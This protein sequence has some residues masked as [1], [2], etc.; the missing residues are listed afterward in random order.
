MKTNGGPG[1]PWLS[2]SAYNEMRIADG[3]PACH[4]LTQP[5]Q[6]DKLFRPPAEAFP[7]FSRSAS[8]EPEKFLRKTVPVATLGFHFLKI[9][10]FAHR[11]VYYLLLSR[12]QVMSPWGFVRIL[13]WILIPI[14]SACAQ[15]TAG[16]KLHPVFLGSGASI[17]FD[18]AEIDPNETPSD[19]A[20]NGMLEAVTPNGLHLF[21]DLDSIAMDKYQTHIRYEFVLSDGSRKVGLRVN[22][23][24]NGKFLP[25]RQTIPFE[26]A[27]GALKDA[28]TISLPVFGLYSDA[29]LQ[30]VTC[31]APQQVSVSG[32]SVITLQFKNLLPD[33]GTDIDPHVDDL[34]P[35]KA[36]EWQAV[37]YALL[38]T[39]GAAIT[40]TP[41]N[42]LSAIELHIR[43]NFWK[44]VGA[45]F[46][47]FADT[48]SDDAITGTVHYYAHAGKI[49]QDLALS[50]PI[51]F[52][53]GLPELCLLAMLGAL[54]GWGLRCLAR[55]ARPLSHDELVGLV[56]VLIWSVFCEFFGLLLWQTPTR[57]KI[58][59]FEFN[60]S[61]LLPALLMGFAVGLSG[62]KKTTAIFLKWLGKK[63]DA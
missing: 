40:L 42:T 23:T 41:N 8:H 6:T 62:F 14:L 43:P 58:A 61:R 51:Q 25:L 31:T 48:T 20:L 5:S 46:A 7:G 44:A 49:P 50:I 18:P 30:C 12:H 22:A 27:L 32:E 1:M 47:P 55:N 35:G 57:L 19:S 54:A 3:H 53:P 26:A 15:P 52:W 60:P 29:Y 16:L 59:G 63:S 21:A 37:T 4:F 38:G 13:F 24:P 10:G 39:P 45:T 33:E 9:A 36:Q 56:A 17:N 28:A 34:K 11:D 2:Q